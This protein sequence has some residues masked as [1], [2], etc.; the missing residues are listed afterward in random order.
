MSLGPIAPPVGGVGSAGTSSTLGAP[1]QTATP[2]SA[3]APQA[4][5]SPLL[6]VL[7]D[8]LMQAL[9]AQD[10]LAP[11]LADLSAAAGNPALPAPAQATAQQILATQTPLDG[12]ATA[13]DLKAAVASS[14]L[15]LEAGLGAALQA[16][17]GA[18]DLASDLKGLL[19]QLIDQLSPDVEAAA[20]QEALT[21]PASA[22][23]A[24]A[25][26][27]NS[28]PPPPARDGAT[29]AQPAADASLDA[30]T[31]GASLIHA[32][33]QDAQGALA[34]V[35]LS[36][37]ASLPKPGSAPQWSFD[38]PVAAPQGRAMAQF[39]VSRDDR[40]PGAA[41]D[42]PPTWRARFSLDVE[43]LGPIHAEVMMSGER[44]RV[45]LWGE[46]EI[47]HASLAA[48]QAELTADL[49]QTPGADAAVRVLPGAP[50]APAVAAGRL[51]D[52]T[53]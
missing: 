6:A 19:L 5:A 46:R 25:S 29:S 4:L 22:R 17:G 14:G 21:T 27:S 34:R 53:S 12:A 49:A 50:A 41:L 11:L 7:N 23:R 40:R 2:Q 39:R 32:L 16:G 28:R 47:G 31:S 33:R 15:F 51:L 36:Q 20:A 10:S 24:Q 3:T 42:A 1:P 35:Q 37:L 30:E 13:G 38:L 45:T 48:G 43:P 8:L 9:P 26:G 44:T 18:P 52:R